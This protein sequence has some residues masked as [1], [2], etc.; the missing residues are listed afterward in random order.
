MNAARSGSQRKSQHR[1][2]NAQGGLS[3]PLDRWG[4]ARGR[5]EEW[6]PL[7]RPGL[8]EPGD[9]L[10]ESGWKE[11]EKLLVCTQPLGKI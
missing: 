10:P 3:R 6:L 1:T 4:L 7:L 9:G 11:L 2:Q 5:C 8:G